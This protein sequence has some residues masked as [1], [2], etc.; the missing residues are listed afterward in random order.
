MLVI[1]GVYHWQPK[2]LAFRNDYCRKCEA[3]SLSIL[4]R[5]FDVLH[6][7]WIPVLPLGAWSRWYCG[8]CG[9]RPHVLAKTRRGFK[10]AGMVVFAFPA[11]AFWF[12][13][14]DADLG[15]AWLWTLRLILTGLALLTAWSAFRHQPE[16]KFKLRLAQVRP[17]DSR[18]CPFCDGQLQ[19][20]PTWHCPACEV[21]HRPLARATLS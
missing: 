5:T 16:P 7:F 1:H 20:L 17:Y 14:P 6:V 12:L 2:R 11:L 19:N 13:E 8:V 21:E 9:A 15:A 4:V 18:E 3:D 10:I